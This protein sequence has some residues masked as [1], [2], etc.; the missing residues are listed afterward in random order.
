MQNRAL[1][2]VP[3]RTLG[4]MAQDSKK[5]QGTKRNGPSLSSGRHI[6]NQL[7]SLKQLGHFSNGHQVL[8]TLFCKLP[9]ISSTSSRP[10]SPSRSATT[11]LTFLSPRIRLDQDG[12]LLLD[13][14]Q[15]LSITK[16]T[17]RKIGKMSFRS[18]VLPDGAK[19]RTTMSNSRSQGSR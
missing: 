8:L 7:L 2:I 13:T 19:S 18:R 10:S 1:L 4:N 15:E 14:N 6:E 5:G 11:C 3:N 9:G 16:Q 12:T 17:I